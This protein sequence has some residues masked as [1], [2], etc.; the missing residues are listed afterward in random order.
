MKSTAVLKGPYAIL[1]TPFKTS[2][3]VDMDALLFNTE[4]L[5]K[6][7]IAGIIPCGSTGEFISN[8][9][10]GNKAILVEVAKTV[11]GRKRLIGGATSAD[12]VNT[13]RYIHCLKEFGYDAALVAPP[14]YFK[15]GDEEIIAFYNKIGEA[16]LPIVAYH[17]PLFT[18]PV[19]MTAYR[20]LL[21]M[22]HIIALKNS[23]ANIKE[24][25]HQINLKNIFRPDF[26]IVTGTD[27]AI[28][29]CILSGCI[30]SFTALAGIIPNTIC[31][32]YKELESKH[33]ESALKL[34]NHIL[35]LLRLADS[36]PFPTGYKLLAHANG[37]SMGCLR[38]SLPE[39]IQSRLNPILQKMRGILQNT[40]TEIPLRELKP[41]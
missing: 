21:D 36:V 2:G 28:F 30:G 33:I 4:E 20:S 5:C 31:R 3:E 40:E 39:G 19:S 12:T 27:D 17:I 6:T 18:S 9:F 7:D 8:D 35:L 37:F 26:Q 1:T 41:L 15:H 10:S 25:M 29:P 38:Q 14:F 34:Q 11:N 23:S 16:A 24:M 22:N 13:L 32:L